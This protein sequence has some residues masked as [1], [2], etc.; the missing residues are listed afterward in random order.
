MKEWLSTIILAGILTLDGSAAGKGPEVTNVDQKISISADAITLDRL[1]RLWDKATGMQSVV[2]AELANRKLSVHF[3]DLGVNDALR[4]MFDGQPFDYVLI[5]DHGIVVTARSQKESIAGPVPVD[6]H[7]TQ[8]IQQPVSQQP[9]SRVTRPP[10]PPPVI[11]TPFGPI[12]NPSSG[13]QPVVQLPQQPPTIVQTPFGPIWNPSGGPQPMVQLP[14]QPPTVIQ[15]PFGPIWNPS[16]G[17]QPVVQLPPVFGAPP[18]PFFAPTVPTTP[19]AGAPNGPSQNTLFG[20][21]P[22]YQN[23]GTTVPVL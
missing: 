1:L 14:Q 20:P 7:V 15:T 11:Q 18:P 3:T 21:L 6:N 8:V 16:G 9:P 17:P 10:E 2:P 4:K 5:E 13:P 22:I 23:P 12:W 19:P